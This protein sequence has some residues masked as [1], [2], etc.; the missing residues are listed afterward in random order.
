MMCFTVSCA[1]R[2]LAAEAIAPVRP[3]VLEP[4]P[5]VD[6]RRPRL[7]TE[8]VVCEDL[9]PPRL[10]ELVVE[11]DVGL[12]ARLVVFEVEVGLDVLRRALQ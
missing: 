7:R 5:L 6:L 11:T 2:D 12:H 10:L 8:R 9:P 1:V 3:H 4:G